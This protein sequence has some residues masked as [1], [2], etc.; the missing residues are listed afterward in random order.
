MENENGYS[1][2]S[3]SSKGGR[4][5][6]GGRFE[7]LRCYVYGST[8]IK[9]PPLDKISKIVEQVDYVLL[10]GV[11]TN[12]KGPLLVLIFPLLITILAYER[13]LRLVT[14][15]KK[16]MR[17]KVDMEILKEFFEKRGKPIEIADCELY[18]LIKKKPKLTISIFLL[19]LIFFLFLFGSILLIFLGSKL[20]LFNF[21]LIIIAFDILALGIFVSETLNARDELLIKRVVELWKRGYKCVFI[22]RGEKH[23][24]FIKAELGRLGVLVTE[25]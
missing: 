21:L 8:H 24:K 6:N 3:S 11:K 4:L 13:I 19:Q 7:T 1:M 10:E 12:K 14:L 18:D 22:A 16:N 5:E 25:L 9:C 2:D 20:N 23:V 15:P 17:G